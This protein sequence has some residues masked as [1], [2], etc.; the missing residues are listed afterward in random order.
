MALF[1]VRNVT[2][3]DVLQYPDLAIAEGGVTF[4]G[5]ASGSGKSTLLKLLCGVYSATSGRITYR[6]KRLEDYEPVALR[7]EVLLVGQSVYLFD[8]SIRENFVEYYA[9]RDLPPPNE[10]TVRE[11]LEICAAPF[12]LESMCNLLSGGERQ[13]VFLAIALSFEPSVLLLDEPTSAL[14]DQTADVVMG[15]VKSHCKARDMTLIVV[16]HSKAIAEKYADETILLGEGVR[17]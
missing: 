7:R 1:T 12:P 9:Y 2:Y 13:R 14:D 16:S 6:G 8:K 5:G 4:L 11:Y 15:Q 3:L 10:E 17:A